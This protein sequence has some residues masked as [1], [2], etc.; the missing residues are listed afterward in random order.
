[1]YFCGG[2]YRFIAEDI[3]YLVYRQLM[4]P[5][6]ATATLSSGVGTLSGQTSYGITPLDDSTY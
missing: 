5:N 6:F 1:M 2:N 3:S 4:T